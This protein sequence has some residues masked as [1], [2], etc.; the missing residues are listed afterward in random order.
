MQP[1]RNLA[2]II[3]P[4]QAADIGA[5]QQ[6]IPNQR[7]S[8]HAFNILFCAYSHDGIS[9]PMAASPM[10]QLVNASCTAETRATAAHKLL[11]P[12]DTPA[13][14]F[15]LAPDDSYQCCCRPTSLREA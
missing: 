8:Q 9:A 4:V 1:W 3:A 10:Q 5:R 12:L 15:E 6:N 11:P 7:S 2:C 13:T 14:T